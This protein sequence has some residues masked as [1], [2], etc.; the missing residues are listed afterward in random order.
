MRDNDDY[1][2]PLRGCVVHDVT[3]S[4]G[5][6]HGLQIFRRCAAAASCHCSLNRWINF[7]GEMKIADDGR[8]VIPAFSLVAA[9]TVRRIRDTRWFRPGRGECSG[10]T[11]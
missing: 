10:L 6:R 2:S 3:R 5:L 8:A 7:L 11:D 4:H 1:V 9:R